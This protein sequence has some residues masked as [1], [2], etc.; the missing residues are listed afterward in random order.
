MQTASL[1]VTGLPGTPAKAYDDLQSAI[2]YHGDNGRRFTWGGHSAQ[3]TSDLK[4]LSLLK[5]K[6]REE[7]L[8]ASY[9]M[10]VSTCEDYSL[11]RTAA[12]SITYRTFSF[13]TLASLFWVVAQR[14]RIFPVVEVL[15]A[16]RHMRRLNVQGLHEDPPYVT[17][18]FDYKPSE[19]ISHLENG[20]SNPLRGW[21]TEDF[22]VDV[23]R[24]L[25]GKQAFDLTLR[26]EKYDDDPSLAHTIANA[27]KLVDFVVEKAKDFRREQG[28][29][30]SD[31]DSLSPSDLKFEED[32]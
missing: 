4:L 32:E 7:M 19:I 25:R 5:A 9:R 17:A 18:Y 27:G 30:Y 14:N 22:L 29:D 2:K 1:V 15:G 12:G 8:I 13:S 24:Y 20:G 23:E 31:S 11:Q 10:M 21:L 26:G 16:L 28:I 3:Q 6:T